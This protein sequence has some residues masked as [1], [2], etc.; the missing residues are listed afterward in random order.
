MGQPLNGQNENCWR[1]NRLRRNGGR[2]GRWPRL[3]RALVRE[4]RSRV[5]G[6]VMGFAVFILGG[7]HRI[8]PG[9]PAVQIDIGAAPGAEWTETFDLRLAAY[10]A[11][12]GLIA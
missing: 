1:R 3:C 10:G 8:D 5:L 12:S 9:Q 7:R 2:K 4:A 6:V 11:R